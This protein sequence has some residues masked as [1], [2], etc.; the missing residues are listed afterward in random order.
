M[1][2]TEQRFFDLE[3][4]M[5]HQDRTIAELNDVITAQWK[6]LDTLERQIGRLGEEM[7]AM[8][9]EDLPANQKPPHY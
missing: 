2:R 4:R 5:A 8:L 1:I 3:T 6:K 9:P 7:E